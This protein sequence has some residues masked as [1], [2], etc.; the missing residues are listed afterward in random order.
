VLYD[1]V[2]ITTDGGQTFQPPF[3]ITGQ[4]SAFLRASDGT[5]YLGELAGVLH[6][7]APGATTW[8]SHPAPHFRCL[9]QRPGTSRVFACGDMGLDG[10]SVGYSDDGGRTFQRMMNFI[11]LLGPLT[12]APVSNNCQAHWERIQ[13]VLG[14]TVPDGGVP[15]DAGPIDAGPTDAGPPPDAGP[16]PDAGT[17]TPL[18]PGGCSAT[19][20]SFA[21]VLGLVAFFV[22]WRVGT[23]RGV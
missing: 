10:F 16:A 13:G 14:I 4:S 18:K 9:G 11:D 19:D 3:V 7:R 5:L 15:P 1:S 21:S 12:C 8:T 20:G 6:V 2:V 17:V 23:R 22:L